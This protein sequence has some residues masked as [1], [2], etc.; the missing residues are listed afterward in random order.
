MCILW[1]TI[2]FVPLI[3]DI[4]FLF[5][6]SRIGVLETDLTRGALGRV[7]VKKIIEIMIKLQRVL[8]LF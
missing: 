3:I 6:V 5:N 2:W 1:W 7:T 8:V 4:D